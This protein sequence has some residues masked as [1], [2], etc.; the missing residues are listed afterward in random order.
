MHLGLDPV[1]RER[2]QAHAAFRVEALHR[3]HQADVAFLDQVGVRQ[4]IAEVAARDG[5]HEAQV[6][7]NKFPRRF[8]IVGVAEAPGERALFLG[9]EERKAVHGLDVRLQTSRGHWYGQRQGRLHIQFSSE[10]F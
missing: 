3:L 4:A 7:D 1:D 9:A 6:R 10:G 2:D 5:D 8:E